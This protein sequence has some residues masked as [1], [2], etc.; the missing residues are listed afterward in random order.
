MEIII[1]GIGVVVGLLAIFTAEAYFE[2]KRLAKHSTV[3]RANS[4]KAQEELDSKYGGLAKGV[5]NNYDSKGKL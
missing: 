4:A 1:T 2:H 5:V 3:M